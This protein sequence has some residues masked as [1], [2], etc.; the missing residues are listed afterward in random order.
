MCESWLASGEVT[1]SL[2][3]CVQCTKTYGTSDVRGVRDCAFKKEVAE[4]RDGY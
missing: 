3:N 2:D 4:L 1:S